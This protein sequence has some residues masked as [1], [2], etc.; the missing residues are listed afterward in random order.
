MLAGEGLEVQ[1]KGQ[2]LAA[3]AA[4]VWEVDL[5]LVLALSG[6]CGSWCCTSLGPW[7]HLLLMQML[8]VQQQQRHR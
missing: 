2:G 6:C 8:K 3:A 4:A 1:R 7:T 5:V